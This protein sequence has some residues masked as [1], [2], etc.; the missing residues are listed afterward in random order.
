[1]NKKKT[2]TATFDSLSY[3][4]YGS[5]VTSDGKKVYAWNAYPGEVAKVDL[6]GY[7]KEPLKGTAVEIIK[8]SKYRIPPREKHFLITSP[9]QT[10]SYEREII[11]KTIIVRRVWKEVS[12][13]DLGDGLKCVY[14][15]YQFNYRNSIEFNTI[16]TEEGIRTALMKRGRKEVSIVEKSA[17]AYECVN[18]TAE[19]IVNQLTSFNVESSDIKRIIIRANRTREVI[20]GIYVTDPGF[21]SQCQF[22]LNKG[23]KGL[24]VYYSD[25]GVSQPVPTQLLQSYGDPKIGE[26][27]GSK[28][29]RYG[30]S[31]FFQPNIPLF[32]RAVS[33]M[34]PYVKGE[35]IVDFYSGVGSIGVSLSDY[36]KSGV[37]VEESSKA[38]EWA[39]RNIKENKITN[40]EAITSSTQDALEHITSEKVI[41]LDP[42]REGLHERVVRKLS[43]EKPKRIIYLSCK[44]YT[45]ARDIRYLLEFYS[46]IFIELYNFFP[47][48]PHIESLCVLERK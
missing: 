42:P 8:P 15:N 18:D 39:K 14:D 43:D 31:D 29:L 48:T 9:W 41:V 26:L 7:K 32:E 2:V 5:G 21:G 34:R 30:V 44:P 4:G 23:L 33:K 38:T 17:L 11:W 3:S 1:M 37:L 35:D 16:D 22:T 27:V 47:R 36:V 12:G 19:D 45:Q 25:S 46:L 24:Q 40:M 6:F 20:A 28:I 13:I 10:V